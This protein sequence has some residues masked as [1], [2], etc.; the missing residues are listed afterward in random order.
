VNDFIDRYNAILTGVE[1]KSKQD[2]FEKK[3]LALEEANELLSKQKT[4]TET[5]PLKL[6]L[7]RIMKD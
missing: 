5:L 2:L 7:F 6:S 4:V 3:I 1:G